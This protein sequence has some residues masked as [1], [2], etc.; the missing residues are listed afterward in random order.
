MLSDVAGENIGY[1]AKIC[2]I[3]DVVRIGIEAAEELKEKR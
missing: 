1:V 3:K 2:D